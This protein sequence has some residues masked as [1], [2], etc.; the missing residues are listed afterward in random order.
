MREPNGTLEAE[1]LLS[2]AQGAQSEP[3]AWNRPA[4][5]TWK[6]EEET[7]QAGSSGAKAAGD[8]GG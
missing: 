1:V 8:F 3:L 2:L 4:L 6:L 5:T 7:L